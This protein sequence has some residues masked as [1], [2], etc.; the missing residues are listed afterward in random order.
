MQQARVLAARRL[1]AESEPEKIHVEIELPRST[2][3]RAGDYLVVLP[4][5][6]YATVMRVL[7]RFRL[8]VSLALIVAEISQWL[9]DAI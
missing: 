2:P 6:P 3:F 7:R 5:N 8:P 1:T 4:T 9:M